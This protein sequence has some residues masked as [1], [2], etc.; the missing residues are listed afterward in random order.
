[1]ISNFNLIFK[2]FLMKVSKGILVY[3]L[4]FLVQFFK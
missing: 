3:F 4:E 1:M 2:I